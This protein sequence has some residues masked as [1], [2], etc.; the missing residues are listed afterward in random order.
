MNIGAILVAELLAH[1]GGILP[2]PRHL[3]LAVAIASSSGRSPRS[4][5]KKR[6]EMFM[7][8]SYPTVN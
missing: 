6:I 2:R 8:I 1:I 5:Y 7:K 4:R 3:A